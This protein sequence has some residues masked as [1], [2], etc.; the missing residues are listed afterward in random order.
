M[1]AVLTLSFK[2]IALIGVEVARPCPGAGLSGQD[3]VLL[4]ILLSELLLSELLESLLLLYVRFR[5]IV[6]VAV[7]AVTTIGVSSIVSV[8]LSV[9]P[10]FCWLL[11]AVLVAIAGLY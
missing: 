2:C 8:S 9:L 6:F 7:S 4:L 1:L 11:A 5:K 3:V 10:A